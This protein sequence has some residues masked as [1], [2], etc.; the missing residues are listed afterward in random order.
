MF[1]DFMIFTV[2][3]EVFT[4]SVF[5]FIMDVSIKSFGSHRVSFQESSRCVPIL[6]LQNFLGYDCIIYHTSPA[7]LYNR[8]ERSLYDDLAYVVTELFAS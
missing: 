1:A 3:R 2:Y 6:F 5:Q 4:S 8:K 7:V